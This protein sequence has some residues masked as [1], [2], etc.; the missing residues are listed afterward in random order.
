MT[1]GTSSS[2]EAASILGN[3]GQPTPV[4]DSRGWLHPFCL[5]CTTNILILISLCKLALSPVRKVWKVEMSE[6]HASAEQGCKRV[7]NAFSCNVFAH[8]SRTLLK[9]CN[10]ISYICTCRQGKWSSLP[11]V[12]HLSDSNLPM[13]ALPELCQCSLP[14]G[15]NFAVQTFKQKC[16]ITMQDPFLPHIQ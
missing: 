13:Q 15:M 3:A 14:L 6:H 9:D 2:E 5:V 7:C 4:L 12:Q 8:M 1:A 16:N 10:I 11:A